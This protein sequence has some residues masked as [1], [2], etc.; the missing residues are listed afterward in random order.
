MS[1][2]MMSEFQLSNMLKQQAAG[3]FSVRKNE[4]IEEQRNQRESKQD[5]RFY[6]VRPIVPTSTELQRFY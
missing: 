3:Q 4:T 1:L 6:V 5:T 2:A